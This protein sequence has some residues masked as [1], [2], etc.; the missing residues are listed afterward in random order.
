MGKDCAPAAGATGPTQ[1]NTPSAKPLAIHSLCAAMN[2][3]AAA[4]FWPN[5]SNVMNI[6]TPHSNGM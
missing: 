3:G 4:R 6:G 1:K 2:S 5:F